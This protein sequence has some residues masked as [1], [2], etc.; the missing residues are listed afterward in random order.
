MGGENCCGV[1]R[2]KPNHQLATDLSTKQNL[3]SKSPG[4]VNKLLQDF[5]FHYFF[6]FLA[7]E[8][9]ESL[10]E[11]TIDYVKSVHE[12]MD[13]SH[14]F[15]HV[16]RVMLTCFELAE[17]E[18]VIDHESLTRIELAALLHDVDDRKYGNS[19]VAKDWLNSNMYPHT[20]KVLVII[21]A[22]SFSKNKDKEE[23]VELDEGD[24]LEQAIVRD[25]DRLDALG[26]IG[27]A[28]AFSFGAVKG[29][30]FKDTLDHFH[31]KLLNLHETLT[32]DSA[33]K[34]AVTRVA[35]MHTFVSNMNKE[36]DGCA[37][38]IPEPST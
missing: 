24:A 27:I 19:N 6:L 20:Q 36:L 29:H 3:G 32:T 5:S 7:M 11:R 30:S 1:I 4:N 10:I 9:D 2:G 22:V 38:D 23:D 18:G 25:A 14:D 26:A 17:Q 16:E 37:M 31:E 21:D 33:K 34:E 8:G 12:R 28:R 35:L 15:N 13:V